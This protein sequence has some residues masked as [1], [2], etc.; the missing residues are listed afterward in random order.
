MKVFITGGTGYIGQATITALR[1]SGHDVVAL[2]RSDQAAQR[3]ELLGAQ[4]VA[5]DLADTDTL[6][7]AA[8][9]A[10]AAIHLAQDYTTDTAAADLGAATAIQRGLGSRPYVHTGGAWVYGN[11]NGVV[12]ETAPQSPPPLTS[13]RPGNEQRVLARAADGGHPVLVIPGTVYGR[14]GGLIAAFLGTAARTG[15]AHYIGAGDNYWTV[16]H[17]DD[18]AELYVAA[19]SAPAGAA[20]IGVDDTQSPTMRQ[21][22]EAVSIGANRPGT[23]S[24]VTLEQARQEFGPFADAFSL[25]QRLT[26][27]RARQELNWTPQRHDALS[28]FAGAGASR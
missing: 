11:T 23:A 21:I 13:W 9:H 22:A 16:V 3:L 6:R 8:E 20:Y 4:A 2:A 25:S 10:D 14:G 27:A 18:L 12:D 1:A 17:V 7:D 28:E 15:S 19:L 24:S 26:A 5:G